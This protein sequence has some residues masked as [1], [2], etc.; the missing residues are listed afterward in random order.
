M[1]EWNLEK[2]TFVML[3]K[4][5][6]A[7]QKLNCSMEIYCGGGGGCTWDNLGRIVEGCVRLP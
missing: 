2:E 4:P 5:W 6:R 3:K 1:V 7:Q